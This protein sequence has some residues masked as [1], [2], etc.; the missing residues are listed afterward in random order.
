MKAERTV[1]GDWK[2]RTKGRGDWICPRHECG[3]INFGYRDECNLCGENRPK[4]NF[5]N[6]KGRFV[7]PSDTGGEIG[8]EASTKS[9]GLFNAEDWICRCGNINWAKRSACHECGRARIELAPRLG[10]RMAD[11]EGRAIKSELA[12][13]AKDKNEED[14]GTFDR[15]HDPVKYTRELMSAADCARVGRGKF[16]RTNPAEVYGE[17]SMS[18]MER[19]NVGDSSLKAK[20]DE[21]INRHKS[22][23]D[24]TNELSRLPGFSKR[25]R[26]IS[27]ED[28]DLGLE[29]KNEIEIE[30]EMGDKVVD[31]NKEHREILARAIKEEQLRDIK[32]KAEKKAESLGILWY[33]D[34][35]TC[36]EYHER[37]GPVDHEVDASN[38][39]YE[40][41]LPQRRTRQKSEQSDSDGD[42]QA[43][44]H[45]WDF[46]ID[47][48][49][50]RQMAEQNAN[51]E[52]ENPV[53]NLLDEKE[54]KRLLEK[55]LEKQMKKIQKQ[56]EK[57]KQRV[58]QRKKE[59]WEKK[60]TKKENE[61]LAGLDIGKKLEA[62]AGGSQPEPSGPVLL[63]E[64]KVAKDEPEVKKEVK[65]EPDDEDDDDC[66]GVPLDETDKVAEVAGLKHHV[67]PGGLLEPEQRDTVKLNIKMA[68]RK[69]I[70][71]GN[72]KK[73]FMLKKKK[74]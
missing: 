30:D 31:P 58:D 74:R 43:P 34:N 73:T 13:R 51:A 45:P 63:G 1:R 41:S 6:I 20:Y 55:K 5:F 52:D 17:G 27:D 38:A 70:Q 12:S 26:R 24:N 62:L 72:V 32:Y 21:F 19:M 57:E 67:I 39:N 48:S 8:E 60:K 36:E 11:S 15:V 23:N 65:D 71:R 4:S 64:V 9:G 3:N 40:G 68:P 18:G 46:N 37:H 56:L 53:F 16:A 29:A 25:Q 54:R 66:D 49:K 14:N 22:D 28:E 47:T 10:A 42:D 33:D 50:S 2:P 44:K 59:K 61:V 7:R 35:S 69:M